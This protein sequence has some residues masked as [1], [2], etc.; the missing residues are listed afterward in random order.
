M[1]HD[2]WHAGGGDCGYSVHGCGYCTQRLGAVRLYADGHSGDLM[3]WS[4]ADGGSQP[5]L[6]Q[7][8]GAAS[9]GDLLAVLCIFADHHGIAGRNHAGRGFDAEIYAGQLGHHTGDAAGGFGKKKKPTEEQGA[10][11]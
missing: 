4:C 3:D 5:I 1:G 10:S 6:E 8:I 11:E 9:C 2:V 7:G